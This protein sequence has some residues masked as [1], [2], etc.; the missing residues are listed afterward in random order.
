ML[1]SVVTICSLSLS[2][3]VRKNPIYFSFFR[4]YAAYTLTIMCLEYIREHVYALTKATINQCN[5]KLYTTTEVVPKIKIHK[6]T[7]G[8]QESEQKQHN[9]KS[10]T[11]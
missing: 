7:A 5:S 3:N 9:S 1:L 11:F 8:F 6:L 2:D 10:R 4:L